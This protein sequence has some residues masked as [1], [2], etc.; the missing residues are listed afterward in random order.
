MKKILFISFL[1]I[2]FSALSQYIQVPNIEDFVTPIN[3]GANMTIGYNNV[4]NEFEGGQIGAFY[5]LNGDGDVEVVGLAI[6]QAGFFGLAIWGDDSSTPEKDGLAASDIPNFFILFEDE[7]IYYVY[8]SPPFN[9]Y[10][11][12]CTSIITDATTIIPFSGCPLSWADNYDSSANFNDGSCYRYGCTSLW[13]DNYDPYATI[14]DGSCYRFGCT[15]YWADNYDNL[16]TI[17]DGSCYRYGCM[18]SNDCNYDYLATIEL[19]SSCVGAPGCM[20]PLYMEYTDMAGCNNPDLCITT[21]EDAYYTAQEELAYLSSPIPIDLLLGWNMIGYTFREPQDLVATM[22]EITDII[23]LVKNNAAEI[24]WP[25]YGFNGI[26]DLIP[27]Q[28][29]QIKVTEEYSGFTYLDTEGQRIEL[30]PTVPQWA[31]DMEVE[32][33]PNDIR[34]LVR[35]VNLLGQEVDPEMEPRGSVLL[36][37]YNDATVEKKL[38]E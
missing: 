23:E 8:E 2:S 36:Y 13:A 1:F 12:N 4:L 30:T 25:E 20:E 9:G 18:Q 35:V 32:M 38:V 11:T 28:G 17:N 21:W 16:A 37:L 14:D 5:D 15:S 27:G 33:H 26:G 7:I 19:G 22:Q 31:I 34:T 29:Y 3:T 6:I 10:V 24:Y